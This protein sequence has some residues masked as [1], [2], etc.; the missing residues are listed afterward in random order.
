[1]A[2][3][4]LRIDGILRGTIDVSLCVG[5]NFKKNKLVGNFFD[6][7]LVPSIFLI[8]FAATEWLFALSWRFALLKS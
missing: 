3:R 4:L 8:T 5:A 6:N 1:M 2:K 7:N